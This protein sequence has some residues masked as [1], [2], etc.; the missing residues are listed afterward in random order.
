MIEK[1][2][3][4]NSIVILKREDYNNEITNF[5]NERN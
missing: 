2:D 1:F 5:V 3:K 4:G